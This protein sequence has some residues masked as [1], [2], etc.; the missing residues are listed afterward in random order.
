MKKSSKKMAYKKGGM[1]KTDTKVSMKK[2][3][4]KYGGKKK[5]K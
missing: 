2:S 5:K 4:Y 3:E 1:K